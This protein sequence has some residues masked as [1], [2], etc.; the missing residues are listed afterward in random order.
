MTTY[1]RKSI[2]LLVALIFAVLCLTICLGACTKSYTVSFNTFDNGTIEPQQVKKDAKVEIPDVPIKTGFVFE[3]WYTTEE[4]SD[5]SKWI[6]ETHTV[7][8]DMTMYA[9][10]EEIIHTV[11]FDS[12]GGS[13]V[14]KQ[15]ISY[16]GEAKA[17]N[18]PTLDKNEFLGWFIDEELE[19][20]FDFGTILT[21]DITLYEEHFH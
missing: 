9:K 1:K 20:S 5:D 4:C 14:A 16:N 12:N 18:A 21:G 10:F 3:G 17:P 7:T 19:T 13:E 8:S 11:T 2:I 6:F 15:Y